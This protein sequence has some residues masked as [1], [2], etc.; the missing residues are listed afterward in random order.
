MDGQEGRLDISLPSFHL[1]ISGESCILHNST[2]T[3][4]LHSHR[5]LDF[6][7][8]SLQSRRNADSS[9]PS[10]AC[11]LYTHTSV[12]SLSTKGSFSVV[13]SFSCQDHG[14]Y[15]DPAGKRLEQIPPSPPPPPTP[16]YWPSSS[17]SR[18]AACRGADV[19]SEDRCQQAENIMRGDFW[20]EKLAFG[21]YQCLKV[22]WAPRW[23][24]VIKN[25]PAN[26][27][28]SRDMGLI[29]GPGRSPGEGNGNP[30]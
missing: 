4:C 3:Q 7:A 26:A 25:P 15:S 13:S 20:A 2:P 21:I 17:A 16:T 5:H 30:L 24:L 22:R 18:A 9:A 27:G 11:S 29:P 1:C 28:G 14:C 10:F 12:R 6:S 19:A 23:P 8:L